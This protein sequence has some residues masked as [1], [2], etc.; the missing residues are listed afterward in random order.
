MIP[1][2]SALTRRLHDLDQ[3]GWFSVLIFIP[4]VNIFLMIYLSMPGS[5]GKNRFGADPLTSHPRPKTAS[6]NQAYSNAGEIDPLKFLLRKRT[7]GNTARLVADAFQQFLVKENP[8][9]ESFETS[10]NIGRLISV[11]FLP[12]FLAARFQGNTNHPDLMLIKK[13]FESGEQGLR[14]V[15]SA[16]LA[17]EIDFFQSSTKHILRM[18]QVIDEELAKSGI[19]EALISGV[20]VSKKK[21]THSSPNRTNEPAAANKPEAPTTTKADPF[22]P[23]RKPKEEPKPERDTSNEFIDWRGGTYRGNLKDGIPHG[24]GLF[25]NASGEYEGEFKDGFEHGFGTFKTKL[26]DESEMF[27]AGNFKDGL[28]NGNGKL[29]VEDSVFEGVFTES[30]ILKGTMKMPGLDYEGEFKNLKASGEGKGTFKYDDGTTV[31]YQGQWLEQEPKGTGGYEYP[32]GTLYSGQVDSGEFHGQGTFF[33]PDGSSLKASWVEG[34]Y[35]KGA[36]L[37]LADKK[38]TKAQSK[39]DQWLRNLPDDLFE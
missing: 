36:T 8:S 23:K 17:V 25:R 20:A 15:V 27:Y 5:P 19:G 28:F 22:T 7:V 12:S 34:V 33:S 24:R 26:E 32:N 9:L 37:T 30:D 38:T 3:N 21:E 13:Y 6:R 18:W 14:G 29:I 10:E 16:I 31:I 2:L 35:Q 11:R 39:I 4:Y 1:Y